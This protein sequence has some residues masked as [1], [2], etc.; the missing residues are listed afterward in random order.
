MPGKYC[1][2]CFGGSLLGVLKFAILYLG[3]ALAR[4]I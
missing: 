2:S 3:A 4:R 1:I